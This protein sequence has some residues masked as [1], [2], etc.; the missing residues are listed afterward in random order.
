MKQAAS[1]VS[2]LVHSSTLK[3][4]VTCCSKCWLTFSELHGVITITTFLDIIHHLIF[5]LKCRPVY[6]SKHVSEIGFY[7]RPQVKPTQ[8]GLPDRASLEMGTSSVY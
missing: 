5:Y 8:L 7:L 1:K 4:E 2:F 6:I 3:M